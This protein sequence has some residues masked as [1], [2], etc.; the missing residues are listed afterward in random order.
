[1]HRCS[2]PRWQ[3]REKIYVTFRGRTVEG[4][5]GL[6]SQNGL[7]LMLEFRAILDIYVCVM[8]VLWRDGAFRDLIEDEVVIIERWMDH[9]RFS[10]GLMLYSLL[11]EKDARRRLPV[12]PAS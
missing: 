2:C 8:P 3:Q 11:I 7:R 1:M 4:W 10:P 5:V 6:V 12:L 9:T